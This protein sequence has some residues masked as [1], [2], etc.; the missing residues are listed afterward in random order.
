MKTLKIEPS[1]HNLIKRK[2]LEL[3]QTITVLAN[4]WMTMGAYY[5]GHIAITSTHQTSLPCGFT[6]SLPSKHSTAGV[7]YDTMGNAYSSPTTF[8]P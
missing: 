6:T 5:E 4:R 1:L 8:K 2:A 3:D 7:V